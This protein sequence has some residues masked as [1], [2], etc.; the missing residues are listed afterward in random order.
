MRPLQKVIADKPWY[1][2]VPLGKHTLHSKLKIMCSEAGISGH[3]TNHSL[4]VTA[5]TEMFRC[6]AP[7]KLIQERTEHRSTE[8]LQ[9]YERLDDIQHKAASSLLSNTPGKKTFY[10][11]HVY[12]QHL[13][14]STKTYSITIYIVSCICSTYASSK[15]SRSLWLYNKHLRKPRGVIHHNLIPPPTTQSPT[16]SPTMSPTSSPTSS[17]MPSPMPSPTSSPT[18]S[19]IPLPMPLSMSSP[20]VM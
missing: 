12:S 18:T 14:S 15:S 7:E 11:I 4:R 13:M 3:K 2:S 9:S 20:T 10:D 17:P 19:P 6:G 8:A 5:A 16:L 1:S